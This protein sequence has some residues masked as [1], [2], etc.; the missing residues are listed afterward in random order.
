MPE[1]RS[2]PA[3]LL[4]TGRNT[5]VAA[6]RTV[7]ALHQEATVTHE[8]TAELLVQLGEA[9]RA[10]RHRAY[11]DRARTWQQRASRLLTQATVTDGLLQLDALAGSA[12]LDWRTAAT[13][14]PDSTGP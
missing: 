6:L 12:R 14:G 2:D 1:D 13:Q 3:R 10:E 7:H 4:A 8:R 5:A 11:A 9:D